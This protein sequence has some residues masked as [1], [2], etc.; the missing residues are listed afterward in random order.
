MMQTVQNESNK[1]T[2]GDMEFWDWFYMC[3]LIVLFLVLWVGPWLAMLGVH[4]EWKSFKNK[5]IVKKSEESDDFM[6]ERNGVLELVQS[7][8]GC[9]VGLAEESKEYRLFSEL[10][11]SSDIASLFRCAHYAGYHLTFEQNECEWPS[12]SEYL[13]PK[14]FKTDMREAA[15]FRKEMEESRYKRYFDPPKSKRIRMMD[16]RGIS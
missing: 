3:F 6:T 2:G 11:D 10:F 4:M 15:D 13:D 16:E 8:I 5:T 12:D 14:V 9:D 7:R 1:N